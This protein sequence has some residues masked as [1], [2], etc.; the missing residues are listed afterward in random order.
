MLHF[1]AGNH[2]CLGKNVSA[3]EMWCVVPSLMRTFKV[4]CTC[5]GFFPCDEYVRLMDGCAGADG[6]DESGKGVDYHH[7]AEYEAGECNGEGQTKN[8]IA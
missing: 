5:P 4:S 7:G 2:L 1:G 8:V 6:V 3:R